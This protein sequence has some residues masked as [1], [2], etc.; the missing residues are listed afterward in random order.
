MVKLVAVIIALYQPRQGPMLNTLNDFWKMVWEQKAS[1]IVMLTELM[2]RNRMK[3]DQ[4]WP[5]N[6]T[7]LYGFVYV[8][9]SDVHTFATYVVRTFQ[10][11]NVNSLEKRMLTQY[12]F[13]DWPE[14]GV[15]TSPV[16]FLNFVRRV[17]SLQSVF[18]CPM[19][20]HCSAGV[21]RTGVF[22]AADALLDRLQYEELVDVFTYVT[23]LRSQ[24]NY[25]I[26]T[27]EQYRFLYELLRE[28]VEYGSTEVSADRLFMY[29]SNLFNVNS[30]T[31]ISEVQLE[32]KKLEDLTLPTSSA[33]KTLS[34]ANRSKNRSQNIIPNE[35]TRVHLNPLPDVSGSD[36]INANFIDS[37][38]E[39]R[40][41]IACQAPMLST[42]EDFWRMLWE[43]KSSII[44]MLLKLK[45]C[46]KELCH[47]YWPEGRSAR[48]RYFVVDPIAQYNMPFYILREFKVTDARD[49]QSRIIRQFQ[50]TDWPEQGTPS[51]CESFIEFIG[52]I[53]KT[54][55]QFG[56]DNPVTVHCCYGSGRTGVFIGLN[57]SLERLRFEGVI[58]MFQTVR[59][60]KGQRSA[61]VQTEEQYGFCYQ[62]A[63]EYL[64]SFDHL[65]T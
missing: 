43:Q 44:V 15:P 21:G 32:F 65:A 16:T 4:Y 14:Q 50:Y 25:M 58:D 63:L 23:F 47:A 5:S 48:Y 41:F 12:Q 53:Q 61:L 24:R 64:G 27:E 8:S 51:S 45:E 11:T 31:G 42:C 35:E 59:L 20:V 1:S 62:A 39:K 9:L 33:F 36:Y 13:T 6:S 2:E 10:L 34:H 3:C 22:I 7:E 40:A 49:G 28:A 60:I 18:S 57:N 19:I 38:K 52:H 54:R 29:V 55:Q 17:K 30:K 56:L 26:Q 46:G 37:Y